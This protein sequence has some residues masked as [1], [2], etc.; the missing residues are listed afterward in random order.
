MKQT[1]RRARGAR[2]ARIAARRAAEGLLRDPSLT[3]H[4]IAKRLGVSWQQV[5]AWSR[6]TGIRPP[7][8][9][10]K[11]FARMP[12]SRRAAIR[13]LLATPGF[14]IADLAEAVGYARSSSPVFV[15]V[16]KPCRSE[17]EPAGADAAEASHPRRL[18]ARLHAH[19][20]RQIAAFEAVL[21]AARDAPSADPRGG[22][23]SAKVLR[24]L[25][26]LKRLLDDLATEAAAETDGEGATREA[27]DPCPSPDPEALR[28]E[29]A[30]RYE[31]FV[32]HGAAG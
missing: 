29:I 12:P 32:G 26:G 27:S 11:T 25:G 28:A 2:G 31:R 18:R 4:E 19:I 13:T 30:R 15:A 16:F 8:A 6:A 3:S 5:N 10:A 21:D 14:D 20:G 22:I 9:T 24:D 17:P 1:I 23:D 7:Q